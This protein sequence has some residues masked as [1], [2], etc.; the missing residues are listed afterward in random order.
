MQSASSSGEDCLFILSSRTV[1]HIQGPYKLEQFQWLLV[2]ITVESTRTSMAPE[3]L[4][5]GLVLGF[6][7]MHWMDRSDGAYPLLISL[8]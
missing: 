5:E 7:H 3:A 1:F 8:V 4:P 2:A 6:I